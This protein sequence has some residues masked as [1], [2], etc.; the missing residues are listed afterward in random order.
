MSLI[1]AIAD[2]NME[3]L[4][5]PSTLEALVTDLTQSKKEN[6]KKEEQKK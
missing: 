1:W 3:E 5:D 6:E 4:T 2:V